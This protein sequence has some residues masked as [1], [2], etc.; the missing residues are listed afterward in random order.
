[1]DK[2]IIGKK[3]LLVL[4]LVFMLIFVCLPLFDNK[5]YDYSD[6]SNIVKEKLD[7]KITT[8]VYQNIIKHLSS[9]EEVVFCFPSVPK[10]VDDNSDNKSSDL[11]SFKKKKENELSNWVD[12]EHYLKNTSNSINSNI[13]EDKLSVSDI[14][15]LTILP[16]YLL[17]DT[18][19]SCDNTI[20][21]NLFA[22]IMQMGYLYDY[23]KIGLLSE[24][25]STPFELW[26][27]NSEKVSSIFTEKKGTISNPYIIESAS[28]LLEFGAKVNSGWDF[29]GK[30]I[31]LNSDIDLNGTV[32]EPIGNYEKGYAFCGTFNGNGHIINN[33]NISEKE[34]LKYA[35]LFNYMNG[36]IYNLGLQNGS[37]YGETCGSFVVNSTSY[38]SYIV[39]C[40]STLNIN[41]KYCGAFAGNYN[42][43]IEC[44]YY[45]G[46]IS[47]DNKQSLAF[48]N[49]NLRIE[50][51]FVDKKIA[52]HNN[53]ERIDSAF[54]NNYLV[55]TDFFYTQEFVDEL[56]EKIKNKG[57]FNMKLLSYEFNQD[58]SLV[59]HSSQW[60]YELS[61]NEIYVTT[62][63][64]ADE[65]DFIRST[66][67]TVIT[68]KENCI[69]YGPYVDLCSGK[70]KV[71]YYGKNIGNASFDVFSHKND[72]T[73]PIVKN[74]KNSNTVEYVVDIPYQVSDIE[75]RMKN[76][77][78]TDIEIYKIVVSFIE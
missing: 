23:K 13:E 46:Q 51:C 74:L 24:E 12:Y 49:G 50:D 43:R 10:L 76:D 57:F 63:Y 11:L 52:F 45:N 58:K 67:S 64:D 48:S 69:Q 31:M 54:F 41:G 66:N 60:T 42:G 5:N 7:T 44:C 39:N 33:L 28:D 3:I 14:D 68:V 78:N 2:K 19:A 70:Y 61:N 47:S 15:I 77:S 71:V 4:P 36:V 29:S 37:L 22:D 65:E 38:D 30:S 25:N 59:C 16:D 55:E 1:M 27:R 18:S 73:F 35:G 20:Y 34:K 26:V 56:N 53:I 8:N 72:K 6:E 9:P 32:W 40:Y 75:F 17:I 21:E 62:L